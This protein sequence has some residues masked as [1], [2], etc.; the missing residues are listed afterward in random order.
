PPT[1]FARHQARHRG[2][3]Q[4]LPRPALNAS[5]KLELYASRADVT[6]TGSK[7]GASIYRQEWTHMMALSDRGKRGA[8]L[9]A[10]VV[11][12]CATRSACQQAAKW[13]GSF[14]SKPGISRS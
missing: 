14:S 4:H 13:P 7:R 6:G 9:R 5:E 8:R 1:D 11:H 12:D 2:E 3:V 10:E